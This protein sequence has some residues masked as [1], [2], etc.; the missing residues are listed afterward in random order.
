V[1]S[2]VHMERSPV[3]AHVMDKILL[4]VSYSKLPQ[5]LLKIDGR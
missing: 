4:M 3:M 5:A 1:T 2:V